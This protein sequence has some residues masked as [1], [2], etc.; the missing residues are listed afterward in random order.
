MDLKRLVTHF[1]Y[2]IEAKPEGGFIARASDPSM[3]PLEA[4]TRE[5]L[6]QKI[7]TNIAAAL[8]NEFPSLKLPLEKNEVN[9]AFHIEHKPDGGLIL[10]ST[11][12]KE[13]PIVG[14]THAEIES[15][16]AE[17]VLG[18]LGKEIAPELSQALAG[19]LGSGDVKV[20]V[21]RNVTFR[22]SFSKPSS[23]DPSTKPNLLSTS[24]SPILPEPSRTW[25]IV[26]FLFAALIVTAILY[27]L[28][29]R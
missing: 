22:S 2:R 21:K 26:R 1:T 8:A 5:E 3:P 19:K 9:F 17:R 14:S 10:Q 4:P 13:L 20:V 11:D 24:D 25:P 27:F 29:H 15:K 6:Q 12:G 28:S 7:Q 18:V 16:L 23:E